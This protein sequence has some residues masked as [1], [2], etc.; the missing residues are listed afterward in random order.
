MLS[1]IAYRLLAQVTN[2]KTGDDGKCLT[3]LPTVAGSAD[4][5]KIILQLVFGAFGV[6]ALIM[7]VWAAFKFVTAQGEPQSLSKARQQ[8]I[9]AAI[10]LA[11]AV[12]AEMIVTFVIG[13]V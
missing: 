9:Y 11:V 13:R 1:I 6:I 5:I 8:I 3:N 7:I 4:T 10:G 12:S 2:C